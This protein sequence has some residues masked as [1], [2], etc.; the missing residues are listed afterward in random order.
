MKQNPK[1]RLFDLIGG[2]TAFGIE[3]GRRDF[4]KLQNIIDEYPENVIFEIC[5]AGVNRTDASYPR[6]SVIQLAK[7]LR[8]EKAFYLTEFARQDL[9][10]NWDYAA[11]A[12]DQNIIVYKANGYNI[13]GKDIGPKAKELL[14]YIIDHGEVTTSK[15]ITVFDVSAQNASARLKKLFNLGLVMGSKQTAETGGMEFVYTAVK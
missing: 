10:D 2:D 9:Q 5:L 14:D 8:G 6:E 12:K 15:V 11:T 7:S 3:D 4:N 1:I 13:L